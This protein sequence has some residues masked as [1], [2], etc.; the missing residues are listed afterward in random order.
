MWHFNFKFKIWS[1]KPL[2]ICLNH[3]IKRFNNINYLNH[4]Y[5]LPSK[6]IH[7]LDKF[8]VKNWVKKTKNLSIIMKSYEFYF[9]N[10]VR[11]T[12]KV[13]FQFMNMK[14]GAKFINYFFKLTLRAFIFLSKIFQEREEPFLSLCFIS[15]ILYNKLNFS[16]F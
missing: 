7:C 16:P 13:G 11:L 15:I 6:N 2:I 5:F 4:L 3:S 10:M 14:I 9:Q 12:N 1:L 8:V